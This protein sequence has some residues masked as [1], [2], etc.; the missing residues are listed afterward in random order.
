MLAGRHYIRVTQQRLLRSPD[1][2]CAPPL[3]PL[4]ARLGGQ[5]AA[6]RAAASEARTARHLRMQLPS[7]PPPCM[8]PQA[9]HIV[10]PE[11]LD[12]RQAPHVLVTPRGECYVEA[13]IA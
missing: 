11:A 7:C 3:A 1:G 5:R 4:Q 13:A 10:V 9:H 8:V 12:L 6:G 2:L